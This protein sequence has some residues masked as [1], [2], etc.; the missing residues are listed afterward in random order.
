MKDYLAKYNQWLAN[1][2]DKT[3]LGELKAMTEHEIE[4][5]F[6]GELSFGTA[7]LRGV[8]SAGTARMNIYTV[9]RATEGLAQYMNAHNLTSCA[10]TY[11]S[12]N[13]SR[14]FSEITA[15]TLASHGIKVYITRECMPTPYLS[16]MVR[17]LG[18]DTGVNVTA[19]HN[20]AEYNGYKVY[21]NLGCQLL[22]DA[23]NEVTRFIEQVQLFK[24]PLPQFSDY[25]NKLIQYTSAELE[26]KYIERVLQERLS[27]DPI[28]NLKV[29]Y[30]PLN[31]AG[32]R[33]VP[34]VLTR[35]GLRHLDIVQE[36]A[37]PN[38]NFPTCPYPNP[39][40]PKTLTLAREIATARGADIVIAND[41]DCDRLGVAVKSG[42]EFQQLS[43][44]EVGV[45]LTDYILTRLHE[46]GK[47]PAK[48]VLVKTIVTTIMVDAIAQDYGAEV[49]DV[50]TGFKYIG[51]VIAGLE[52]LG[53]VDSYLFGF[54]ESCGYLKGSYVRDKDGVIASLLIAECAAYHK[55]GG[56]TL[57][58][59]LQQLY[60]KYGYFFQNTVSYRFEGLEGERVKNQLL[61]SLR[62]SPQK[63]L[64]AS[65]VTEICDFLTQTEMDLPKADVLRYRSADG[66]QLIV[67]PS[68]TEPL[69]K[70][71]I[72]VKGNEQDLQSR[73]TAIKQQ[74][75]KL[76][77][78]K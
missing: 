27:Q 24:H 48:P 40:L 64:G 51:N 66:S 70:C 13:N 53:Q 55:K 38:G 59:R 26:N 46:Q 17:E 14:L 76:F 31:G 43:G 77:G 63:K 74:T 25:E 30:S 8:M 37:T 54:E 7:G 33:I 20:P 2:T 35:V 34:E 39:E 1:V 23:A 10:I 22:D 12:R 16:F 3:L 41:P 44:N 58:D 68:G 18:C 75:D 19:S 69:I 47:L 78:N 56:K 36:Q 57:L 45:L 50:L 42:M 29:V 65:S 11:D 9:Y 49:R 52:K 6:S 32:Y 73:Y 71:Y 28:D 60:S 4:E 61:R 72:T 62:K 21:D 67:R 5:A 15:A